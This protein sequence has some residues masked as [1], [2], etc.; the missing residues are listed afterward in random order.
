MAL[1]V[2]ENHCL[3]YPMLSKYEK[4]PNLPG[5]YSNVIVLF[6]NDW[7]NEYEEDVRYFVKT[8]NDLNNLTMKNKN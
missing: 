5:C 7:E 2:P 4:L 8:R 6:G 3:S 1:T